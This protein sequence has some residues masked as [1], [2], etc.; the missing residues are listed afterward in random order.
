MEYSDAHPSLVLVNGSSRLGNVGDQ[1]YKTDYKVGVGSKTE[2]E[3]VQD[4]VQN[5]KQHVVLGNRLTP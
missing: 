5:T 1:P 2:K 3:K 4:K